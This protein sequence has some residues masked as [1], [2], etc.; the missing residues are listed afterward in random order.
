L[1]SGCR[2]SGRTKKKL[3]ERILSILRGV[4]L[5]RNSNIPREQDVDQF[6]A[7]VERTSSLAQRVEATHEKLDEVEA[8][9]EQLLAQREKL[10]I[11]LKTLYARS[12]TKGLADLHKHKEGKIAYDK[13]LAKISK[14]EENL[15]FL[16]KDTSL[17]DLTN[18]LA[19]LSNVLD[20]LDADMVFE[21]PFKVDELN[22]ASA[23]LAMKSEELAKL[24]G[25]INQLL[26]NYIDPATY[27][28][29]IES[30]ENELNRL[31]LR[32][33]ALNEAISTI[34]ESREKLHADFAPQL[35]KNISEI[36]RKIT[37][38]R[39]TDVL[40]S[41]EFDVAV[42]E[43]SSGKIISTDMLSCGTRDQI[44]F[45]TRLAIAGVLS[46]SDAP[47]PMFF[48]DCFVEYDLERASESLRILFEMSDDRQILFFTCHQREKELTE[49]MLS[50]ADCSIID[51]NVGENA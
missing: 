29:R 39:Y 3:R 47:L 17:A 12:G 28:L 35:N 34:V 27:E 48:D 26:K 51:L 21:G 20:D 9:R 46:E 44:Y 40:I 50:A 43:P 19:G 24:K 38:G 42:R 41:D 30:A 31:D 7:N 49:S 13:C 45:A 4:G 15:E 6:V 14:N 36:V 33:K 18:E 22:K 1:K 32:R 37:Y 8:E 10:N 25:R 23:Q 5:N 11:D 2:N 16:L